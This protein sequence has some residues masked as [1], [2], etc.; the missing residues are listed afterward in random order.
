MLH[1]Q[2]TFAVLLPAYFSTARRTP[3]APIVAL[4]DRTVDHAALISVDHRRIVWSAYACA[5]R[6]EREHWIRMAGVQ[7]P[8]TG[9]KRT[10]IDIHAGRVRLHVVGA[11]RDRAVLP[12]AGGLAA[13]GAGNQRTRR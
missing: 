12:G 9:Y 5:V 13:V 6:W 1:A 4:A 2:A 10:C 7:Q 11:G 3:H 8:V